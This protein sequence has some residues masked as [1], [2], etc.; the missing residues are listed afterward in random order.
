MPVVIKVS[1][2]FLKTVTGMFPLK[3][4]HKLLV[5]VPQLFGVNT[6]QIFMA[7]LLYPLCQPHA[8]QCNL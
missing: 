2:L 3:T 4:E 1:H 8:L 7:Q 5:P 6:D